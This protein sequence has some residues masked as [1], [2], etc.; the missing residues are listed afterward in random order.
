MIALIGISCSLVGWKM[1]SAVQDKHFQSDL[2][3]LRSQCLLS[4]KLAIAMQADWQ[5][6]LQKKGKHWVFQTFCVESVRM[7]GGSP[8]N[9]DRLH[10][11]VDGEKKDGLVFEFFSSGQVSPEGTLLFC[12]NPNDPRALRQEWKI[13]DLFQRSEQDLK[14]RVPGPAHP[15]DK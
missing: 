8:I 11:F 13:P 14:S 4:Q 7:K 3:R 10:L 2:D 9:M 1:H 5:G 12:Q 6:V 15:D